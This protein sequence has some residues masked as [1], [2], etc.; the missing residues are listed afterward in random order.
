MPTAP[1]NIRL[2][3][4]NILVFNQS[5]LRHFLPEGA[6]PR[7][8]RGCHTVESS[9]FFVRIPVNYVNQSSAGTEYHLR[10]E[11]CS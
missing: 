11:G 2:N 10:W 5:A 8:I 1:L 9:S 7:T 6:A 4:K 3:K